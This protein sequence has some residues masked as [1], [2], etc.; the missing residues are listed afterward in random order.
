[1]QIYK[2]LS[3]GTAKVK[4]EEKQG[5]TH[6]LID[7]CSIK[8][9]F[10][11]AEFKEMCYDKII[12][13]IS[14][15]KTPVIVGGTGLYVSSVV[16]NMSFEE[17]VV[18]E[19]Y[20][21]YLYELAKLK[22]NE[23]V[24]EILKSIDPETA[25]NV[26]PNNLKRVIRAIEIAKNTSKLKSEHMKEEIERI[27]KQQPD[28]KFLIFYIH[29]NRN[30]LYER[31]NKRVDTMIKD[32]LL[33]EAKMVYDMNLPTSCTCM[34]SIG[35]KEF[36]PYFEGEI[37]LSEAIEKLKLETRKYAKRQETWF[38]NKLEIIKIDGSLTTAQKVDYI[39]DYLNKL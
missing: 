9:K 4:E 2:E 31:I 8:E 11:V 13:I 1:M 25:S 17:E 23:Y 28:F 20:R 34:Q 35:Y 15:E 7:I 36:F 16:D 32:G 6:H 10:S 18:D 27:Q 3:V 39:I 30:V 38:K 21:N 26:H 19:E 24:Y 12:D 33:E 29:Y 37:S 14:R 22:S 5:I